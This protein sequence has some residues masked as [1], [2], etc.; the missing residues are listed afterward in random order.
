LPIAVENRGV[1]DDD[2]HAALKAGELA[3]RILRGRPDDGR[4]GNEGEPESRF[5]RHR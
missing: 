4:A 5:S 1:E 3:G 2:V